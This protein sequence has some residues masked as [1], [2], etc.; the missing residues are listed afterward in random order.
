MSMKKLLL[1][2]ILLTT[3]VCSQLKAQYYETAI[4]L[5]LGLSYGLTV[6]HMITEKFAL[7]GLVTS[8][9]FDTEISRLGR[10]SYWTATPGV[11][12][13]LLGEALT[14]MTWINIE[15]LRFLAGGGV[16]VGVWDGNPS[17]PFF[18]TPG[19]TYISGGVDGIFGVEYTFE[20]VPITLQVDWKPSMNITREFFHTWYDEA[21]I[22][23]RYIF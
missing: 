19:N 14:E 5:R 4:G 2:G 8:C 13:T 15:G 3:S 10:A 22:S 16:H 20:N 18:N 7:E 9:Y 17:N 12:I 1:I 23:A 6:K 11:K 21:A